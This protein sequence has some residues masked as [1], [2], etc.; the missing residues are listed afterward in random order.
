MTT[1]LAA[2]MARSNKTK[3]SIRYLDAVHLMR[4]GQPLAR[5]HV[6]SGGVGWFI[7]PAGEVAAKT[8][9][10]LLQRPDVQPNADAL[11]PGL[12]QTYRMTS[13]NPH[14]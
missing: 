2:P 3:K 13:T 11:F 14:Q 7:I 6:N 4:C 10:A 5:M 8:A 1:V 9:E 12:G